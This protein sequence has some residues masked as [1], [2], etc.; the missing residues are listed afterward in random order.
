MLFQ[1]MRF[2]LA[3]DG[4]VLSHD[5]I[6]FV[7]IQLCLDG[8]LGIAFG[9]KDHRLHMGRS[10][11]KIH[12]GGLLDEI[13]QLC[14]ALDVPG[15]GGGVAGDV[16]HPSGGHLGDGFH[17]LGGQALSGRVHRHRVGAGAFGGEAG[18]QIGGVSAEKIHVFNA[19]APGGLFLC[20]L[21]YAPTEKQ[22]FRSG[23]RS[24]TVDFRAKKLE[25]LSI[26]SRIHMC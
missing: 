9:Q 21:G 25:I 6:Q 13:S 24:R 2:D 1:H 3:I 10:G 7:Q 16:D 11:E 22:V 20:R 5:Q 15:Q 26:V 12:G 19:V 4:F 17:H 23:S 8:L 14:K 18:G